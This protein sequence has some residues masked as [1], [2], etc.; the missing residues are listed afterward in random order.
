MQASLPQRERSRHYGDHGYPVGDDSRGVVDETLAFEDRYYP[1][2]DTEALGDGRG[3]N[4]VRGGDDGAQDEGCCPGKACDPTGYRSHHAGRRQH[5][6]DGE[7]TYW[8]QVGPEITPGGKYCRDV[9]Q[10]GQE[11]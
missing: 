5:E 3:R 6:S 11:E 9:E 1:A 7:Q 4:R 8:P 10:R 2:R